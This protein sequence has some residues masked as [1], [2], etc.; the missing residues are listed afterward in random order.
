MKINYKI[1]WV[2]FICVET[3]IFILISHTFEAETWVKS[4]NSALVINFISDDYYNRIYDGNKFSGRLLYCRE[5]CNESFKKL[6]KEWCDLYDDLDNEDFS[7]GGFFYTEDAVE[8]YKSVCLMYKS[9]YV[10]ASLVL[11]FEIATLISIVFWIVGMLVYMKR[12]NWIWVSYIS[13]GCTWVLHY[14][15]FFGY[16]GVTNTNF[17]GECTEFP[18]DG[19]KPKLCAGQGPIIMLVLALVI[20]IICVLFCVVACNLHRKHGNKGLKKINVESYP[21]NNKRV[22]PDAQL[23]NYNVKNPIHE[24]QIDRKNY[25]TNYPSLPNMPEEY[26]CTGYSSNRTLPQKTVD[27]N[28]NAYPPGLYSPSLIMNPVSIPNS[29]IPNPYILPS[30]NYPNLPTQA[31]NSIPNN[32]G[33]NEGSAVPGRPIQPTKSKPIEN[34]SQNPHK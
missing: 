28:F 32:P 10:G 25:N 12:K 33:L 8:I 27:P 16:I 15:A 21:G 29:Y 31:V 7:Y 4:D 9:L 3:I 24:I 34:S 11:A 18:G 5:T 6:S 1:W 2:L 17:Y 19:S 22:L 26:K 20:P 13:S 23:E 30:P 14:I